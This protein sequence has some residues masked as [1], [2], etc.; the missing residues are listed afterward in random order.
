MGLASYPPTTMAPSVAAAAAASLFP[1]PHSAAATPSSMLG[2]PP[3]IPAPPLGYPPGYHPG[4]GM[5]LPSPGGA[6]PTS[7]NGHNASG[8]ST[9]HAK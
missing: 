9:Y 8:S 5:P 2:K 4:L 6:L 3:T 1:P 7:L